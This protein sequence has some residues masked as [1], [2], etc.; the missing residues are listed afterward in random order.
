MKLTENDKKVIWVFID[1][2]IIVASWLISK[3]WYQIM[4]IQGDS[5]LPAYHNMQLVVLNKWDR[6]YEAGDVIAF[7][8]EGLDTVLV[9]RIIACPDDVV[10][11]IDSKLWVNAARSQCYPSGTVFEYAGI[12]QTAIKLETGQYFVIGDNISQSKDSRYE[13]VGIVKLDTIIGKIKE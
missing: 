3:N 1:I 11:I 9:K 12:A 8:C 4:L 5:M 10:E 13:A 2:F 6:S 7:W